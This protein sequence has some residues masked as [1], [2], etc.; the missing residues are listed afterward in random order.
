MADI[1]LDYD[2][3]IQAANRLRTGKGQLDQKLTQ[4]K[5]MIDNLISS[6]FKT[7][8][9]SGKLGEAFGRFTQAAQ[10]SVESLEGMASYLDSVK[11]QHEELDQNLASGG[12]GFR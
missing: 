5:S 8:Q 7:T 4:M 1:N 3:V 2:G 10:K 9:A 11:R 6:Q 12:F